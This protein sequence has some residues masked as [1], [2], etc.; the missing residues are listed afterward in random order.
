MWVMLLVCSRAQL[1]PGDSTRTLSSFTGS[2]IHS[3]SKKVS[4]LTHTRK[5]Q[6]RKG[7]CKRPKADTDTNA[8]RADPVTKKI[9]SFLEGKKIG[10][11]LFQ[12]VKKIKRINFGVI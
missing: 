6:T 1:V 11:F 8:N 4:E 9:A 7:Q 2:E 12:K 10:F 5:N 3:N